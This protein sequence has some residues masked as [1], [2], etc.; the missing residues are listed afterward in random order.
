[1]NTIQQTALETA[2]LDRL[3]ALYQARGLPPAMSI[4]VLRRENTGNG[5]YVDLESNADV[6]MDD[7]YID[8]GGSFIEMKGLPNGM[9]AVALVKNNHLTTLEFTVYGGDSW[10]GEER[11][12]KI[13]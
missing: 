6:Q 10:D 7:G 4:G 12:W 3:R 2:V 13:V 9:M 1:M 5:R 11:E 8:L